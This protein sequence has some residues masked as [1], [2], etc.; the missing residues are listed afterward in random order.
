[1]DRSQG[2]GYLNSMSSTK[3]DITP[4]GA[5]ILFGLLMSATTA[6]DRLLLVEPLTV[7]RGRFASNDGVLSQPCD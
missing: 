6:F 5:T 2:D 7:Q 4:H 1:M 3:I